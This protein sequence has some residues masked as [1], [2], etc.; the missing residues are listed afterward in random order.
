MF[1]NDVV[2]KE[3]TEKSVTFVW[4]CWEKRVICGKRVEKWELKGTKE[5]W[6]QRKDEKILCQDLSSVSQATYSGDIADLSQI[7]RVGI[8]QRIS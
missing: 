3:S 6:D 7:L 2:Y 8:L 1:A 4:T 5:E